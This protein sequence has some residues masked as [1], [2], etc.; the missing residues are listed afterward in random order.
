MKKNVLLAFVL[1]LLSTAMIVGF[2]S[3]VAG[4]TYYI[5]VGVGDW[6]EYKVEKVSHDSRIG[7][8][9]LKLGDRLRFLIF[10]KNIT[11]F[12]GIEQEYALFH[13]YLND[14]KIHETS[15]EFPF[16]LLRVLGFTPIGTNPFSPAEDYWRE[17]YSSKPPLSGQ[18]SLKTSL[19]GASRFT[20]TLSATS[21][22]SRM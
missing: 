11:S 2:V 19:L 16:L 18:S 9:E 10:D 20:P 5:S 14:E 3:L 15:I 13:V 17:N 21:I 6:A 22:A 8:S 4:K 12:N 7:S 1:V